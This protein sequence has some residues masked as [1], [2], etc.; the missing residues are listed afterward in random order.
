MLAHLGLCFGAAILF[1]AVGEKLIWWLATPGVRLAGGEQVPISVRFYFGGIAGSLLQ[2]LL[3][4][5]YVGFLVAQAQSAVSA[6]APGWYVWA[7]TFLAS[8]GSVYRV[9]TLAKVEHQEHV[10]ATGDSTPA[11]RVFA[12]GIT[13]LL[14]LLTFAAL[15]V[16]MHF[17]WHG[18]PWA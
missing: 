16:A 12:R 17:G 1:F 6:G 4:A 5:N 10:G 11:V 13:C 9:Y 2:T 8:I 3:V 15:C 7:P 14:A 18:A